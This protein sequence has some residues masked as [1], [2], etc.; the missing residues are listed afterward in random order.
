MC[1]GAIQGNGLAAT[2]RATVSGGRPSLKRGWLSG[3]VVSHS[4]TQIDQEPVAFV[5]TVVGVVEQEGRSKG[6]G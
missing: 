5:A 4:P 1:I 6:R 2:L 3:Y